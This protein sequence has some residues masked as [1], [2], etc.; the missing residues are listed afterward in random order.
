MQEKVQLEDKF[1]NH[2]NFK[3]WESYPE[4]SSVEGGADTLSY[5]FEVNR[6]MFV[7]VTEII[8]PMQENRYNMM[9]HHAEVGMKPI[10]NNLNAD[11]VLT[12]IEHLAGVYE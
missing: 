6:S 5:L 2:P 4:F 10:E 9:L 8:Q 11:E 12:E 1:I 3:D 7:K